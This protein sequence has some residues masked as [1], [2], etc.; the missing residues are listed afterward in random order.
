MSR[1][2]R[3]EDTRMDFHRDEVRRQLRDLDEDHRSSLKPWRETLMRIFAGGEDA[4]E[5]VKAHLV[6]TP[7]RRSFLRIGGVTVAGAA[8]LAACGKED[9]KGSQSG[10][11]KPAPTTAAGGST[12]ATPTTAP[13]PTSEDK[14]TD[15]ELLRTATSL[16]LLAVVVYGKAAPLVK[17]KDI[18]SVAT[19]FARQHSD[20]AKQLQGATLESF[21]ADK[22]YKKPNPVVKKNL[23]DPALPTL[24]TDADILRFAMALEDAAAATYVTAAGLLSTP[25][26]RQAIM[27]IGGVEARHSAILA[28]VLNETVPTKAFWDTKDAV[29]SDAFV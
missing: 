19:L 16:E 8:V 23:V 4:S 5:A 26:L 24:K 12:T 11:T 27:A 22:V 18:V 17:D 28:H 1:Q 25:A 15:L 2:V 20:H 29:S 14:K 10:S 7:D 9:T 6:G 3:H 21:G 13:P